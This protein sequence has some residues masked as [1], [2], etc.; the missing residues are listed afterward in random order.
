MLRWS[1]DGTRLAYLWYRDTSTGGES[2]VAVRPATGG[3]EQL[4]SGPLKVSLFPYGWSPDGQSLLVSSGVSTSKTSDRPAIALWPLAAAPHADKAERVL[5][6]SPD[7][8][9]FQESFSPNG[10]W[11]V[12]GAA[13]DRGLDATAILCVIPG[14]GAPATQ[15]TRLTDPH[16]WA[17]K[18]RWSPDGKLLYF[19]LRQGSLYNVWALRFDDAQGTAVGAPFQITHFDGR[20]RQIDVENLGGRDPSVSRTGLLLPM[21]DATGSIWMLDNVDK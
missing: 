7:H 17:D 21:T 4:L 20:S 6:S 14:T 8:G 1:P 18:P 5:T 3:D 15:W 16:G 13:D 10:R 11:I 12:F 9:L 2:A 19:W